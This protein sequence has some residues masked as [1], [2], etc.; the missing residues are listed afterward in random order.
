MVRQ[1]DIDESLPRCGWDEHCTSTDLPECQGLGGGGDAKE[2]DELDPWH[3]GRRLALDPGVEE[4]P[5]HLGG[6]RGGRGGGR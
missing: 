4:R 5:L 6:G 3:P 2:V 1:V